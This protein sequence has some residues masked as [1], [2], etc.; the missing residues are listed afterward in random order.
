MIKFLDLQKIN[1]RFDREFAQAAADVIASGRYL[2]GGR[3][4]T[5]ERE[6]AAYLGAEEAVACANGLD[7]LRLIIKA[8]KELGVMA[9]GDEV[10]VPANTFIASI[11]AITDNGLR[12]VLIEPSEE[13]FNLDI[14]KIE[15][16]ITPR[17][18]AIMVVHLYGR[19]LWSEKLEKIAARHDL[20]IIEDNAQAIG[21]EYRGRKSGTLG[22]AAGF[23]FY[24]GKNLGA[25]SDTGAVTARDKE[26]LAT[27]RILA[28]YGAKEKY[29][30]SMQGLN[31]RT[32]E[33]QTA[34]LSIKLK[35]LDEDNEKRRKVANRYITE[36]NNPKIVVPQ[37][38]ANPKGHVWHL[39][40]IRC[41]ERERL[42]KYLA[43]HGIETLIHYPIPPHKQECYEGLRHGPLPL[44]EQ[45]ALEVLSLPMSPLLEEDEQAKIIEALNAF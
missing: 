15:A 43:E 1:G 14:A 13:S 5:F 22:D 34:F 21:A 23:S 10:I 6:L 9:E 18:R 35:R 31:S 2:L 17:T 44:T 4:K 26:L 36:I 16:A 42:Q 24:P 25:L 39:F 28:N 8:Y 45:L 40:V 32:D 30:F 11:L 19:C 33:L 7:A 27:I 37:A 3:T 20:K 29:L 41:R 38:P 12:P